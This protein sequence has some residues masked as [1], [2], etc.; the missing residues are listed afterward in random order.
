[1]TWNKTMTGNLQ[2]SR[3]TY[4][5]SVCWF[6]LVGEKELLAISWPV[7][8]LPQNSF[9]QKDALMEYISC[10]YLVHLSSRQHRIVHTIACISA[11]IYILRL[12][13]PNPTSGKTLHARNVKSIAT[14]I[15]VEKR[16]LS[17]HTNVLKVKWIYS[18][19]RARV[20]VCVYVC[21]VLTLHNMPT[22]E[23]ALSK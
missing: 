21:A 14:F 8:F 23:T 15:R 19:T 16:S 7:K 22:V 2:L 11:T 17:T 12:E 1:M 5:H 9:N 20:C 18:T 3:E 6:E 10:C 4:I 13:H